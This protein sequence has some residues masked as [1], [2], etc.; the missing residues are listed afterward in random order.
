MGGLMVITGLDV[1]Y[2]IGWAE[3]SYLRMSM[4]WVSVALITDSCYGFRIRT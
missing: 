4:E 2:P 3:R 1:D